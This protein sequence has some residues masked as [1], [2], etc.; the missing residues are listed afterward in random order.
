MFPYFQGILDAISPRAHVARV[1]TSVVTSPRLYRQILYMI[2]DNVER[3]IGKNKLLKSVFIF[4][5]AT[6]SF[7]IIIKAITSLWGGS[8]TNT[9]CSKQDGEDNGHVPVPL[10]SERENVWF[11]DDYKVSSLDVTPVIT[12]YKSLQRCDIENIIARNCVHLWFR[13]CENG[14]FLQR[15]TCGLCVSGQIYMVNNHAIPEVDNLEVIIISSD[16]KDGVSSNYQVNLNKSM[17]LRYPDLDLAFIYFTHIPPKKNLVPLFPKETFQGVLKGTY[18]SRNREGDIE[19][20]NVHALRLEKDHYNPDLNKK[21]TL[22]FGTSEVV[23]VGGFCGS[24]LLADSPLGPMILGIHCLGSPEGQVGVLRVTN[25]LLVQVVEKM[26][27]IGFVSQGVPQ[28]SSESAQ[29]ELGNLNLKSPIRYIPQGSAIVYGSFKNHHYRG[30]SK[31][32]RTPM[33]DYLKCKGYEQ[34]YRSPVMSGWEPWYLAIKDMVNPRCLVNM[35]ILN[36]CKQGYIKD[37]FDADLDLSIVHVLDDVTTINGAVGVAYIDKIN[38]NT[39]AGN[40]WKC[41]KRKFL[42]KV[43]PI[44]GLDD[45]VKVDDEIMNRVRN[46]IAG[47][48]RGER[49]HPN[50]CAHL[51][52]EA[53]TFEKYKMKK[54]RVFTGAPMDFTIVVRKY[55]L[56]VV[57]LI[58]NNR[59]VFEMGPGT[60]AQSHEWGEIYNYLTKFGE[61]RIIAGDY[62]KFDKKMPSVMIL[63]AFDILYAICEKAG[64]TRD[65]LNV[66]LGISYDVAFP[67]VDFNGDLIEFY[68]SNP[69]GHPLTVIINSL[70]NSLYMRYCYFEANPCHEVSTFKKNI[71]LFTYGDD[72]IMGVSDKCTFFNHTRL[73]EILMTIDVEYTMADKHSISVPFINIREASF[74]KRTWRWDEDAKAYFC[75][76][77]HDSIEK[78]LMVCVASSSV[79]IEEQAVGIITTAI[80]EYFFYGKEIFH[81]KRDLL[82]QCVEYCNLQHYVQDS[83]FPTWESL[84][85]EFESY[86]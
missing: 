6:T 43:A 29:R 28:L 59:F 27:R 38:R 79:V 61:D 54:T 45:P 69:S 78:M 26:L 56:S 1:L 11:K 73:Q 74:L 10:N 8:G 68:G 22:W 30:K 57:R 76:L 32:V 67:L 7:Y 21:L 75:P 62:S 44:Y 24:P 23:T 55:L 46:I 77:A 66:V 35:D 3:K 16:S 14:K 53:V 37:I 25:E 80:R 84:L 52:D 40:P 60:I 49:A 34:K 4:L 48:K 85:E 70:V 47:Y 58:Q 19:K 13:R 31:V 41:S 39:S 86:K 18:V 5:S 17:I 50:Y 42:E 15:P 12:S 82:M 51:K 71:N 65:D 33:F 63:A 20:I 64:Y 81:K 83:T 9:S 36:T 72:N 2:G